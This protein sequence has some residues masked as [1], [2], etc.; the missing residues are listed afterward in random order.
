MVPDLFFTIDRLGFFLPQTVGAKWVGS[1]FRM[2]LGDHK[3]FSQWM[4]SQQNIAVTLIQVLFYGEN[5]KQKHC[6]FAVAVLGVLC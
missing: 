5:Y 1:V 2:L 6:S 3:S 4:R